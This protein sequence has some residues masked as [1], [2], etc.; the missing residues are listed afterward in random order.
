MDHLPLPQ[1]PILP[2]TDIP[3]LCTEQ[4]DASIPFLDYPRHKD[5]P[6]MTPNVGE[7]PY[8]QR[9]KFH[10][11]PPSELEPFLQSWLFFGLLTELLGSFFDHDS[12][13]S[14]SKKNTSLT[15]VSTTVLQSS[16]EK[17][18]SC[19]KIKENTVQKA[20]YEHACHCIELT[21]KVLRAV[22]PDFDHRVKFSIAAVAEF[23]ASAVEKAYRG[24]FLRMFLCRRPFAKGFY[25]EDIKAK[26]RDANWCP[27]DIVRLVDKFESI[28]LLHFFSRMKRPV[29]RVHHRD[30]TEKHCVA[31]RGNLLDYKTRHCDDCNDTRSCREISIDHQT[32]MEILTLQ[33]GALPLLQIPRNVKPQDISSVQI[34]QSTKDIP[35]V[36]L[37]H[38][39]AD[40]LGN[41]FANSLPQCQLARVGNL[42]GMITECAETP[43]FWLDTLCCP[44]GPPEAKDLALSKM[45]L[46][47][48]GASKVLVLDSSLC[49]YDSNDMSIAERAARILT[50]GWMRRLWT[51]Q[52]AALASDLWFQFKDKPISL[53]LLF[54]NLLHTEDL[55]CVRLV[56]DT[57]NDFQTLR[58]RNFSTQGEAINLKFLDRALSHRATTVPQMKPSVLL[59]LGIWISKSS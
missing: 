35:H 38:V 36:A 4:Y 32:V 49:C 5:K 1:D 24:T 23:L 54:Q 25:T 26:M 16:T 3:Y 33:E 56:E 12:F 48:T 46:T 7:Q 2:L 29:G 40:G 45:R 30:C 58:I 10:P 59:R 6:W 22:G 37:S 15:I 20:L 28:Q 50:S 51:L 21:W 31:Y 27:S 55:S 18:I 41:A 13:V 53:T 52:E 17:W 43:L 11:T 42:V 34:C 9:E 47:Y 19:V 8:E 39:W 57:W 44:V 14:K